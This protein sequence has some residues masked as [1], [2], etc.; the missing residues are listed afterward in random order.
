[1]FSDKIKDFL[2]KYDYF[3]AKKI[4]LSKKIHRLKNYLILFEYIFHGLPWFMISFGC[5][6]F[7]DKKLSYHS[8]K[9]VK[10]FDLKKKLTKNYFWIL[11]LVVDLLIVGLLKLLIRRQ[12]PTFN[13]QKD[14]VMGT[15]IG[16][17]KFSFPSG[18]SSRS[19]LISC[20]LN[21]VCK[22][23]LF[24]QKL[25]YIASVSFLSI[26]AIGTCLSRILLL[27]HYLSDVLAGTFLGFSFYYIVDLNFF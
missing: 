13:S 5:F 21:D 18:H 14:M 17:D 2:L 26:T 8:L 23:Y 16:P 24:N 4:H 9:F 22:Q 27:R 1:M 25:Y 20:L 15:N 12:R 11:G 10:G 6:F 7:A 3:L 19:I